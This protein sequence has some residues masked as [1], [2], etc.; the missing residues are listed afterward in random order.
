MN[1]LSIFSLR[2][3]Y[4]IFALEILSPLGTKILKFSLKNIVNETLS[5]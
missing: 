5:T 4:F 1:S 2:N 3:N